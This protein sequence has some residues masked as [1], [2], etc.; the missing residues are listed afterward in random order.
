MKKPMIAIPIG[1][2]AGVGP[3]ITVKAL[4]TEL[5]SETADCIVIGDRKV[6]EKAIEITGVGLKVNVV[7]DPSE[8]DYAKGVLNLIDLDNIDMSTF[9]YGVV[10]A[11]CGKAAYEYIAKSIE[12]A[13]AGKADAVATT[14]INKEA[15][16]AAEVPF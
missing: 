3:E 7:K 13:M 8:G 14:P 5:V 15:L 2:P 9:R 10:Q 4:A 11:M 6:M 1:D 12:L 16:H